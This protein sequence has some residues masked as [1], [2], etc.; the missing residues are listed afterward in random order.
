VCERACLARVL[1]VPDTH[2]HTAV[3]SVYI[4]LLYIPE[5]DA[6]TLQAVC[7][8]GISSWCPHAADSG[9]GRGTHTQLLRQFRETNTHV[10]F[11]SQALYY[12]RSEAQFADKRVDLAQLEG[13]MV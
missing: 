13:K 2:T 5:P 3:C 9:M 1:Y 7:V 4:S 10:L 8:R 11:A 12:F 6:N